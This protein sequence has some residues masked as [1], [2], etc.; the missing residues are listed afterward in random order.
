MVKRRFEDLGVAEKLITVND[1]QDVMQWFESY[2]NGL[3]SQ[4]GDLGSRTL[5]PVT[6]LLLDINM[7]IIH[8]IEALRLIKEKFNTYNYRFNRSQNQLIDGPQLRILRPMI[9]YFSQHERSPMDNFIGEDEQAELYLQK[10][11]SVK[12]L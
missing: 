12:E 1:G 9:C 10:P 2:L 5:Q 4:D 7:P 11:L 3:D 6:L 8:G